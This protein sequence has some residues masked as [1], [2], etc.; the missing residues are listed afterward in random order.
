MP[1]AAIFLCAGKGTRMCGEVSDKVLT[2]LAQ[3]PVFLFSLDAF[4]EANI[5]DQIV[6]VHRDEAQK[7]CIEEALQTANTGSMEI[8]WSTGGEERQDSVFNGLTEL[9]LLVD[10]VFIHDCARPMIHPESLRLLAGIVKRDKAAVLCHRIVDTI[11]RVGHSRQNHACCILEDVPRD[12]LWG[13]E[14]PQA[15]ERELITEAY[16]RLR[17]DKKKVTDDTAAVS[18]LGHP[19]SLVENPYPNP[20]LTTPHDLPYLEFL[21][22]LKQAVN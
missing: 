2:P 14:T 6:I 16:R 19:V 22:G 17:Y 10:D 9:S 12:D 5:V 1:N 21:L 20:K 11:K 8:L 15:F 13:M 4:R 3:R 7:T 18:L